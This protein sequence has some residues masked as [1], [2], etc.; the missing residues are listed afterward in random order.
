MATM[1]GSLRKSN[2]DHV[3]SEEDWNDN[4]E[5]HY[6]RSKTLAERKAWEY[7]K[8]SGLELV[9]IHPSYVLGPITLVRDGFSI[10]GMVDLLNGKFK[11][12]GIP[13]STFGIADVRDVRYAAADS[14]Q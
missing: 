6:S 13:N 12:S 1:C 14:Q 2:P 10:A 11:E 7:A 4:P 3:W 5:S 8:E 9:T